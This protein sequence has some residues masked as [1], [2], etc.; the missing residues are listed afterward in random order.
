M[1]RVMFA[2]EVNGKNFCCATNSIYPW[3]KALR[4][5]IDSYY[6]LNE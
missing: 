3:K 5:L 4:K 6:R 1:A 2:F